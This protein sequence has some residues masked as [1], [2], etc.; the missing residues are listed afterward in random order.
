MAVKIAVITPLYPL[1][2]I[3]RS[4]ET[5]VETLRGGLFEWHIMNTKEL[6]LIE[7]IGE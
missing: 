1:Y 3:M 2:V 4:I 5:A 6:K 7:I